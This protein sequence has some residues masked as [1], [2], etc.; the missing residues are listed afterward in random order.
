MPSSYTNCRNIRDRRTSDLEDV[1][2]TNEQLTRKLQNP[3]R[4]FLP[5]ARSID[6]LGKSVRSVWQS[7]H[8]PVLHPPVKVVYL[9]LFQGAGWGGCTVSLLNEADVPSFVDKLRKEYPPYRSLSDEQ[10]A[11][12]VFATKPGEGAFGKVFSGTLASAC[13]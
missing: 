3:L 9:T 12:A 5:R 7:S 1:G 4:M 2:T 13:H 11:A 6:G 10:F 8:R